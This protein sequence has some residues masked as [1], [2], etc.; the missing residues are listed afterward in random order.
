M[1]TLERNEAGVS[2]KV[3]HRGSPGLN[4]ALR[5]GFAVGGPAVRG[6][7][8][9]FTFTLDNTLPQDIYRPSIGLKGE[10]VSG[11]QSTQPFVCRLCLS[12][13]KLKYDD[14]VQDLD[15]SDPPKV[16][17]GLATPE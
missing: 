6:G 5:G 1:H 9:E 8:H 4:G 3:V 10:R 7:V 14:N 11:S 16:E 17:S 2:R 13:G 12:T 15:W